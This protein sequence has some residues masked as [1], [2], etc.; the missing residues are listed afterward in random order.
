MPSG[1]LHLARRLASGE[2]VAFEA[3]F[4]E[5]FPR[6][7]RFALTRLR[8]D[9]D[10]AEDVVQ[11]TLIK[12]LAKVGTF[13]GE[14]ALFS[15]LCAFCRHEISAWYARSGATVQ[16]ST[17]DDSPEMR[18]LLD[19]I[20]AM[21][22]DDPEEEYQRRELAHRVRTTLDHLPGRYGDA[23]VWKYL[24]GESVG[25]IARRLGL[26]YKAAESHLTRARQAFRDAFALVAT[27]PL[28]RTTDP[29]GL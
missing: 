26:G 19:A 12:A 4:D 9:E 1:D 28:Q 17:G 25:E 18:T 13:R 10:A 3:F 24:E 11:T 20:A 14:A 7:Y 6:L 16:M 5:Y 15:W 21:S 23:L 2:E 29:D 8:G 22:A 27:Q